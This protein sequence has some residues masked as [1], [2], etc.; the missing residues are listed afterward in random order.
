MTV[1][2]LSESLGGDAPPLVID[3]RRREA[4]LK[5]GK[6]ISGALRRDPD[7]VADW[8]RALPSA[9]Q[10]VV[11]CVHGHEVSQGVARAL[12]DAGRQAYFLEGGFA[13]WQSAGG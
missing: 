4:F 1:T 10:V 9:G 11:A 13:D 8:L 2:Q 12:N 3:V 6:T 7:R 5:D